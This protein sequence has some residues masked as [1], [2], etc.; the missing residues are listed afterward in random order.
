M[1]CDEVDDMAGR[2]DASNRGLGHRTPGRKEDQNRMW[3]SKV[4]SLNYVGGCD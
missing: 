4:D 3:V 1:G 2:E